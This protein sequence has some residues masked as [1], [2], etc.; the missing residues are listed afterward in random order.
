MSTRA[1]QEVA[2]LKQHVYKLEAQINFLYRHLGVTF[3]EDTSP[4]DNPL[5]IEALRNNNVIE[6]IK[7][8]RDATGV[9]LAEAKNAVEQMRSRLGL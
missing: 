1:E 4:L 5:V 2:E 9:G 3:V 8:Y 7:H 6:A